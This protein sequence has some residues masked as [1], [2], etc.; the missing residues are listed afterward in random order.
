MGIWNGMDFGDGSEGLI[1][2]E[3]FF[4]DWFEEESVDKGADDLGADFIEVLVSEEFGEKCEGLL[5]VI[6]SEVIDLLYDVFI[7]F[8]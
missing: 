5:G 4:V 3:G 6:T 2:E 8:G 1:F 7:E